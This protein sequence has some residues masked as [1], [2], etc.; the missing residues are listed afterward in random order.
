[1]PPKKIIILPSRLPKGR[2]TKGASIKPQ[3]QVNKNKTTK[4]WKQMNER[5]RPTP[6][7]QSLTEYKKVP[8]STVQFFGP[9]TGSMT[10]HQ[11]MKTVKGRLDLKARGYVED[12]SRKVIVSGNPNGKKMKPRLVP[13]FVI[14]KQSVKPKMM[15]KATNNA[16][17]PMITGQQ[18]N[19]AFLNLM[20]RK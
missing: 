1:M 11:K 10:A 15:S 3:T 18:L 2:R 17:K 7:S 14:N 16:F 19:Q 4:L 9:S 5:A 8:K 12:P 6:P 13:Q 20:M